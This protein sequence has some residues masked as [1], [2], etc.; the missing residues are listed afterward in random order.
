MGGELEKTKLQK[1]SN[2]IK[3]ASGKTTNRNHKNKYKSIDTD[4]NPNSNRK[5]GSKSAIK[6]TNNNNN[7]QKRGAGKKKKEKVAIVSKEK[8]DTNQE[9]KVLELIHEKNAEKED[10]DLIYEIISKHFFLQTLNH[11]AKNEICISMSL[12]FLK[13]GKTLYTQGNPGNFWY[14]VHSGELNRYMDD[15]LIAK[16]GP[17]DSFGE[18]ALMNNSPRSNTVVSVSDCK[19]LILNLLTA[20]ATA[21][22]VFI[23]ART[24]GKGKKPAHND[25]LCFNNIN[26]FRGLL[27]KAKVS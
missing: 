21:R 2:E 8:E 13:G 10:Y 11:Q 4:D 24:M 7:D 23:M 20:R 27:S 25:C 6:T 12:Y 5:R 15:K 3:D 22:A 26:T 19:L 17:G 9:K 1:K 14:I 18:H 16:I